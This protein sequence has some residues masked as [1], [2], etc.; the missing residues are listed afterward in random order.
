[1]AKRTKELSQKKS[2]AKQ[3]AQSYQHL[4]GSPMDVADHPVNSVPDPQ[5]GAFAGM[6][7]GMIPG[8]MGE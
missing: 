3:A 1:M 7:P 5:G 4:M 8:L 2:K 6:Q